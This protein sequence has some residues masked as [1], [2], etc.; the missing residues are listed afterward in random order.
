MNDYLLGLLAAERGITAVASS[1]NTVSFLRYR[2]SKRG[3]RLGA[4]VLALTNGAFLAQSL[5][6]PLPSG[7]AEVAGA[8]RVAL[9][10]GVLPL[11]TSVAMAGLVL[12]A[13]L[14]GGS[15]SVAGK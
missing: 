3:R 8:L 12:R 6:P 15:K 11:L 1:F 14:H 13:R 9:L 2:S 7:A 4:L 5:V 10:V